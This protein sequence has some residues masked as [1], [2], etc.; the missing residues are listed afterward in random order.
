M[1]DP[2]LALGSTSIHKIEALDDA[3]DAYD[4][5]YMLLQV[6]VN[7]LVNPQPIGI[8]EIVAGAFNRATAALEEVKEAELGLG[9]ESG[10]LVT[11]FKGETKYIDL[12]AVCLLD[13]NGWSTITTSTGLEFPEY[14]VLSS[15]AAN[16]QRSAGSYVVAE[17]KEDPTD[18]TKFLMRGL[19]D[20]RDTLVM[21][22]KMAL[23]R[24][25]NLKDK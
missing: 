10:I 14:A 17:A 24:Y 15:K 4:L 1:S 12:A 16:W 18:A 3:I 25:P 2:I 7:S 21:A 8:H 6:K 9:I 11:S 19:F 13:K 20:R 22:I 5:P 23:L